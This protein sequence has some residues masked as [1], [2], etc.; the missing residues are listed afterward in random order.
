[1]PVTDSPAYFYM[2]LGQVNSDT[3][4]LMTPLPA[5]SRPGGSVDV[6]VAILSVSS[7]VR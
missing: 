6:R 7:I 3:P 4:V 1:M 5:G 2:D